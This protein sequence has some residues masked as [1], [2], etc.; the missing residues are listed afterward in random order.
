[1]RIIAAMML[2][3]YDLELCPESKNWIDQK[4]YTLWD[5]PELMIKARHV[6]R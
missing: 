4:V 2:W 5:K 1:M 6:Q 3:H